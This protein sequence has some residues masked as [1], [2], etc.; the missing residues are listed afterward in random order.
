MAMGMN[1]GAQQAC[2]EEHKAP[3]TTQVQPRFSAFDDVPEAVF[4]GDMCPMPPEIAHQ[5]EDM[6]HL[7][8]KFDPDVHLHIEEPRS[9]TLL[10]FTEVK[11]TPTVQGNTQ[12]PLAYTSAFRL[13]SDEGVRV[14]REIIERNKKYVKSSARQ[15]AYLRG[16][17][18]TSKFIRDLNEHP[19]VL[20]ML[21]KHAGFPVVPHYL[22]MN[23][24]HINLGHPPPKAGEVNKYPVDQWHAD[25]VPFVLIII[26]S[27][28]TDMV[29]GELQCVKRVGREAGF[30]LIEKTNNNV[31]P[32]DLLNVSYEKQ[33]Y[34]LFMQGR[35][36]VHHVTPV[37]KGREPRITLVNSYMP[38]NVFA[39]D[40]TVYATFIDL[41]KEKEAI[42][43]FARGR[44]WRAQNQLK[45]LIDQ[46]KYTE[47]PRPL[48]DHLQRV[49]Q[50]LQMTAD[51]LANRV[52]DTMDYYHEV[53]EKSE[54]DEAKKAAS[55]KAQ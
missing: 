45:A 30:E 31:D 48:V 10:D 50:E 18:Y 42:L 2:K 37:Q 24:A 23:Y 26:L 4:Y 13:L 25:S 46:T 27:D 20:E 51:L 33:G 52:D 5:F 14:L 22:P 34:G 8:P 11:K 1:A 21:S 40:R 12:S 3:S 49:V 44:A 35:E 9:I 28:M 47:D 32:K 15:P 54:H 53:N 6:S 55:E 19:R 17:A 36:I 43:E 29:G 7:E 16:M 41:G 39:P 38:K